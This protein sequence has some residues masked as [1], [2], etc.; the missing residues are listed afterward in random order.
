MRYAIPILAVAIV[1]AITVAHADNASVPAAS[2]ESLALTAYQTGA[3]NQAAELAEA[4]GDS[5]S[6]ALAARSVLALAM[7]GDSEPAAANI[8][9]AETLARTA[10]E[11][12]PT[13]IEGRLQLAIA[14]SLKARPMSTREAMRSGLGDDARALTESVL[15]DDP[16]NAYAHGLMAVW[17]V[18][19]VRRGGSIGSAMMGASVRRGLK[20]YETAQMLSPDDAALHWQMA[21]ALTALNAR[22]YRDEI[23]TALTAA[24]QASHEDAV[25]RTMAARA[26]ILMAALSSDSRRDVEALAKSML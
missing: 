1:W 12:D 24:I 10:L 14:L 16:G 20:H 13:H 22:K 15:E 6:L 21:R 3:F 26:D 9:R 18:E 8:E 4:A 11:L 2:T 25:E 19:V 7:C 17:H 23:D 5:D